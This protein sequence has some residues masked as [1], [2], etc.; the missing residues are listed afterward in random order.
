MF[1]RLSVCGAVIIDQLPAGLNT[2]HPNRLVKVSDNDGKE[3]TQVTTDQIGKFCADLKSGNYK[4][5]V[6][7][8]MSFHFDSLRSG[9]ACVR[10]CVRACVGANRL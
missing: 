2:L 3:V 9:I 7:I 6:G 4:F 1:F 8:V 5:K 10:A